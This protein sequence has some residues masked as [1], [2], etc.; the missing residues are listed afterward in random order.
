[1]RAAFQRKAT[2]QKKAT[3]SPGQ[4]NNY[5]CNELREPKETVAKKYGGEHPPLP[6]KGLGEKVRKKKGM[7]RRST[8]WCGAKTKKTQQGVKKNQKKRVQT[9]Y[10]V[11]E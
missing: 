5:V 3:F 10:S 6:C 7:T 1:L 8:Q 9:S 4:A 2:A 11:L